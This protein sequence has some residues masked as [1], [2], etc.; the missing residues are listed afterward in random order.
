MEFPA[1]KDIRI[2]RDRRWIYGSDGGTRA[3]AQT[4][5]KIG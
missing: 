5:F 3:L 2:V 4:V 1:A